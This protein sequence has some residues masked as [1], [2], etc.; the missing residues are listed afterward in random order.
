MTKK[1]LFFWVEIT[2]Q[3]SMLKAISFEKKHDNLYCSQSK[4]NTHYDQIVAG[5][6]HIMTTDQVVA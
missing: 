4:D 5:M 3:P 2:Y 1:L 6:N